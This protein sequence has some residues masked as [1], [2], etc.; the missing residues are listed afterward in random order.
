[1]DARRF[2][3]SFDGTYI[4]PSHWHFLIPSVFIAAGGSQGYQGDQ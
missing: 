1:M 2:W 4:F 3:K